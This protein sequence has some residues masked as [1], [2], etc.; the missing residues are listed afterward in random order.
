LRPAGFACIT[1]WGAALGRSG[2]VRDMQTSGAPGH[3]RKALMESL[4]S[5]QP[6]PD[7]PTRQ[8]WSCSAPAD[9]A[10]QAGQDSGSRAGAYVGCVSSWLTEH[11]LTHQGLRVGTWTICM[12]ANAGGAE[13]AGV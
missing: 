13:A 11:Q 4:L 9:G 5:L 6:L 2:A 1:P 10:R 3:S 12:C 8:V 7:L